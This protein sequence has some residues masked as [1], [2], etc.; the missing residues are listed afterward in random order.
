MKPSGKKYQFRKYLEM[1]ALAAK[2]NI[3]FTQQLDTS[4]IE[5]AQDD[6]LTKHLKS[7]K[8]EERLV[9][10]KWKVGQNE[11]HNA[12]V[13]LAQNPTQPFKSYDNEKYFSYDGQWKDGKLHGIGT[14]L[15]R[16][17]KTY[18]GE[19]EN[20][21][22]NGNGKAIYSDDRQYT[23]N[24]KNG[25]YEGRGFFTYTTGAKY[26]GEFSMGRRGGE[27]KVIYPCGLVYEGQFHDGKPHGRGIM[28]SELTGWR[29]E[30]SFVRYV[31]MYVY[32]HIYLSSTQFR[33]QLVPSIM[34]FS[35]GCIS[36]NN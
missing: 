29:Y 12:P 34:L 31:I 5:V 17:G 6:D 33:K 11:K 26:M 23:G 35:Y 36:N 18:E 20:N 32:F 21:R 24:W 8:A 9:T 15:F 10:H 19:W 14:Y 4:S 22:Q 16:D 7:M 30:G 28:R 1:K 27:G 3:E 2:M 25:R 13:G